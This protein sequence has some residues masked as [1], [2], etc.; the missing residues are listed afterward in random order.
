MYL[1]IMGGSADYSVDLQQDPGHLNCQR[2]H[3]SNFRSVLVFSVS[4]CGEAVS[5]LGLVHI[6]LF[7]KHL[8]GNM[9]TVRMITFQPVKTSPN[10]VEMQGSSVSVFSLVMSCIVNAN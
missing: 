1:A 3:C 6:P 7:L 5:D 8:M 10:L 9:L 4:M 2:V